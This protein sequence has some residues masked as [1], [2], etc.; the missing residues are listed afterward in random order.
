MTTAETFSSVVQ[1]QLDAYNQRDAHAFSACFSET[2]QAFRHPLD[3]PFLRGRAELHDYYARERFCHAGL[4]A[5]GRHRIDLGNR[6]I[7]HEHVVG[8]G[9]PREVVAIYEQGDDGLIGRVWFFA[10]G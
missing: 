1:R 6:I 7:D 3:A 10:P 2:V 9:A 4:H 5:Q 8:L